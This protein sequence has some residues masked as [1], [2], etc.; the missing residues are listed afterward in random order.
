MSAPNQPSPDQPSTSWTMLTCAQ[1]SSFHT[2]SYTTAKMQPGRGAH[3][4]AARFQVE[5]DF[6]QLAQAQ[7][8]CEET[9][10]AER[11]GEACRALPDGQRLQLA[12]HTISSGYEP[13]AVSLARSRL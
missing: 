2:A 7:R 3:E 10:D 13:Q 4:E 8:D 5:E 12:S 1:H 9:Q 11:A 6:D